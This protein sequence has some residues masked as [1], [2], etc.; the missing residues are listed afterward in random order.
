MRRRP[1]EFSKMAKR[2]KQW[3][4]FKRKFDA[5]LGIQPETE[6][7]GQS[8]NKY[9]KKSPFDCGRPRCGCCHRHKLAKT[10]SSKD[11]RADERAKASFDEAGLL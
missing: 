5:V 11:L 6:P 10:S 4:A 8:L 9:R 2:M 3:L 7:S 1:K